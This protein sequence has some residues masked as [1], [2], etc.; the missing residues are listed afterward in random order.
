M[1]LREIAD[2]QQVILGT[3]FMDACTFPSDIHIFVLLG[4]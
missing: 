2:S 3:A 1:Y 4:E